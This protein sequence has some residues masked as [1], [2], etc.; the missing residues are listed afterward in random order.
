[1]SAK[2]LHT[3]EGHKSA[4]TGA[5]FSPDG[6]AVLTFGGDGALKIWGADTGKEVR[7]LEAHQGTVT[8]AEFS[9]DGKRIVS[10]GADK[11]VKVWDADSGK[12]LLNLDAGAVVA[13]VAFSPDGK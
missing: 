10:G 12:E 3:L 8:G 6:K 1:A 9:A 2:T 5:A 4:V 11:R 7:T 13:A